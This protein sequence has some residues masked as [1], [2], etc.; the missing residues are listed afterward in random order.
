MTASGPNLFHFDPV[1][2]KALTLRIGEQ[3]FP[4]FKAD[5][6]HRIMVQWP[7]TNKLVYFKFKDYKKRFDSGAFGH[8]KDALVKQVLDLRKQTVYM[9]ISDTVQKLWDP[10]YKLNDYTAGSDMAYR[11]IG[12]DSSTSDFDF[13]F[14]RWDQPEFVVMSLVKFENKFVKVFN[15]Y[16]LSVFDMNYYIGCGFMSDALMKKSQETHALDHGDFRMLFGT[17]QWEEGS[18]TKQKH[19]IGGLLGKLNAYDKWLVHWLIVLKM[20]NMEYGVMGMGENEFETELLQFGE[21]FYFVLY[22][23]QRGSATPPYGGSEGVTDGVEDGYKLYLRVLLY[24]M[25]YYQD[26]SYISNEALHF[27]DDNKLV[28]YDE[29]RVRIAILDNFAFIVEYY[30]HYTGEH[31]ISK[32]MALFHFVDRSFKY[33]K[34]IGEQINA[35]RTKLT[36]KRGDAKIQPNHADTKGFFWDGDANAKVVAPDAAKYQDKDFKFE[37]LTWF[38][39]AQLWMQ[40]RVVNNVK[41]TIRGDIENEYILDPDLYTEGDPEKKKVIDLAHSIW[42]AILE[43]TEG[44]IETLWD[45]NTVAERKSNGEWS[46]VLNYYREL[47]ETVVSQKEKRQQL[48]DNVFVILY[49]ICG[50]MD[51]GTAKARWDLREKLVESKVGRGIVTVYKKKGRHSRKLDVTSYGAWNYNYAN[52]FEP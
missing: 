31:G 27:M 36:E 32:K 30:A 2:T 40:K 9:L 38:E 49:N 15:G 8:E 24:F 6:Q 28:A 17:I 3:V 33:I 23:I 41:I 26:E 12:S 47:V 11:K 29:D 7:F 39:L 18:V 42:K 45:Q 50:K 4:N 16:P 37:D 52:P 14:V 51:F 48:E 5:D 20:K 35:L 13:N 1:N 43:K 44:K 10:H 25:N 21:I 19:E 22:H 34:R 46:K